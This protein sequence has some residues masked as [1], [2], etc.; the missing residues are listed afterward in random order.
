MSYN[1]DYPRRE[2]Y[3]E[4]GRES[5]Y[6]GPRGDFGREEF[7]ERRGGGYG[8]GREEY[9][10]E[11][12]YDERRGHFGG[13]RREE[14]GREGGYGERRGEY[15]GG[16]GGGYE[17]ERERGYGRPEG[18]EGGRGYEGER[19]YGGEPHRPRRDDS[20]GYEDRRRE[21]AEYGSTGYGAGNPVH[22]G[23]NIRAD[24]PG[25]DFHYGG[26][27]SAGDNY[28]DSSK[29]F[30]EERYASTG[31][32]YGGGGAYG[33]YSDDFSG[34]EDRALEYAGDSADRSLFA[35]AL[36]GLAGR[37]QNLRDEDLDE[38]DAVRQHR[39]L[40]GD[41]DGERGFGGGYGGG[42]ASSGNL[43]AAAAMQA[44]KMFTG[45]SGGGHSA[46]QG[47]SQNAF[48]GMAMGQAAKL[49]DQQAAA[50]KTSPGANKQ[51]AVASAAQMAL[52]MYLKS[53]MGGGHSSGGGSS[54][55]GAAGLLNMASKFLTK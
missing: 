20:P 19:G 36:G 13:E 28:Y 53:E 47:Q 26:G 11:G 52:K 12:G 44:L 7:D 30:G 8:G 41:G 21:M 25:G 39:S 32:G 17:G 1:D 3:G 33:G 5:G 50:G 4:H 14:F 40:Y 35:S 23:P 48:I 24:R 42:Q 29:T 16:Y 27:G 38:D 46:A 43:G 10:R 54:G 6:S 9:G 31:T 37:R 45:G 15:G 22:G 2:G 51:D 18:Y 49:F 55:G 34:A